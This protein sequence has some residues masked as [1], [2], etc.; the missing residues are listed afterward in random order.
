MQ[1]NKTISDL[2]SFYATRFLFCVPDVFV[3]LF[4]C[5]VR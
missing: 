5:T 4:D 1:K 3:I 2:V